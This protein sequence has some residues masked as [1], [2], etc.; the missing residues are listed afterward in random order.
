MAIDAPVVLAPQREITLRNVKGSALTYAEMDK[1]LSSFF[2]SASL[3]G[4]NLLLHYTGSTVLGVPYTPTSVAVP[5]NPLLATIQQLTVAGL[6]EG[7]IQYRI[8]SSTLGAN[9]TF[10]WD[11]K[12]NRV[13]IGNPTPEATLHVDQA[14]KNFPTTIRLATA[15][16]SKVSTKTAYIEFY[17]GSTS[18]GTFG[19]TNA[20]LNNLYINTIAN[21]SLITTVGTSEITR[22][23]SAGLGIFCAPSFINPGTPNS[24]PGLSVQGF[25]GVGSN[26][27]GN[28]GVIRSI[29]S[30]GQGT[31]PQTSL[32]ASSGTAGLLIES[33]KVASGVLS[34]GNVVIGINNITGNTNYAFSVISGL[35][36]STYSNPRLTVKADGTVG[37][38]KADPTQALD[39]VGSTTMTGNINIDG[40]ATIVTT[41]DSQGAN[42]KVL[43]VN[44]SGLVQYSQN[45]MP[46]GGIIMWGGSVATIPSGWTLCDGG[47]AVNGV[48][49]PDLRERFIVGAGGNNTT[50]EGKN[51]DAASMVVTVPTNNPFT[52][53]PN[54]TKTNGTYNIDTANTYFVNSAGAIITGPTPDFGSYF[55]Y[56][57][58]GTDP[59]YFIYNYNTQNYI[60][61]V[62][63][64][65]AP[66]APNVGI[67]TGFAAAGT[68]PTTTGAGRY[69]TV[70]DQYS[71]N[72]APYSRYINGT[73]TVANRPSQQAF[74]Y[75]DKYGYDVGD[76]GGFSEVQLEVAQMPYHD[77]TYSKAVAGRGYRTQ[78]D[79]NPFSSNITN[80]TTPK[81]GSNPHE[82]R[83]PYYALAF[84][85]YT[86]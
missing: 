70:I 84:I 48:T 40:T 41:A 77:H 51:F 66:I 45:L 1:N 53:A 27:G 8:D 68:T 63:T 30:S 31:V 55:V 14:S 18:I 83:P 42:S 32:P 25:I 56:V 61:V 76:I 75:Q 69:Y 43:T 58:T 50:V 85:I 46:K 47:A 74:Y 13:G 64:W 39:I 22:A 7:D 79:D 59:H 15:N 17:L 26:T 4:T 86:G 5:L 23:N 28:Q 57:K 49:I 44:G 20:S 67:I 71:R 11:T 72:V 54:P 29:P 24:I 80:Q 78:S 21:Q 62:G 6:A 37:I 38:N 35:A 10:K 16:N 36:G 2:Y 52:V 73:W 33:P 12:N 9:S 82:N 60:L 34:G 19:K 81:G 65:T 3:S